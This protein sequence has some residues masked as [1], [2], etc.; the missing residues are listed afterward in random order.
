VLEGDSVFPNIKDTG[1][2]E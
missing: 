1:G 2:R